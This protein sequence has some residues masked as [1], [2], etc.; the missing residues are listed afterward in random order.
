MPYVDVEALKRE[1][2][3]IDPL[4]DRPWRFGQNLEVYLNPENSGVWDYLSDGSKIWRLGI[5]SP[6][7]ISLNLTFDKYRLPKGA[8]MFIYTPDRK[9]IIVHLQISIIKTMVILQQ[10]FYQETTFY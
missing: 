4:K 8:Q 3:Y 10:F 7:A 9:N 6:G 5:V 1:D 2:E